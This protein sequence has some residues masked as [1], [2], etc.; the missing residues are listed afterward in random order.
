MS[1]SKYTFQLVFNVRYYDALAL[2]ESSNGTLASVHSA[3]EN[4]ML[5]QF[6]S[7]HMDVT[8]RTWLGLHAP[9][10]NDSDQWEWTDGSKLD[11]VN[12]GAGQG[13]TK[14]SACVQ[15]TNDVA[16][17]GPVEW[18]DHWYNDP[19]ETVHPAAICQ[20]EAILS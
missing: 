18:M 20:R 4:T 11:Y 13:I 5:G 12:W 15:I 6:A 1:G 14:T 16:S 2:C 3:E 8:T 19:C 17:S 9:N 10:G 7:K